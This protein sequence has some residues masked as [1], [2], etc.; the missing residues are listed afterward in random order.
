MAGS[1]LIAKA[2][3]PRTSRILLAVL[4]LLVLVLS[5]I[6]RPESVFGRLGAY[7]KVEHFT[8]YAV[9]GFFALRAA[10]RKGPL[11]FLAVVTCCTAFGGIIEII[12]PL[13]GR[14]REL[15]DFLVDVAGAAM[16]VVVAALVV[17]KISRR[18]KQP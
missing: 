16:G 9:L 4:S 8:A 15:G 14:S 10:G 12:Q 7:D 17:R 3:S 2:L 5:L 1:T 6:P 11:S 18:G 13:V